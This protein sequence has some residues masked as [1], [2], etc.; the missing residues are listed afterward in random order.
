M[1][2]TGHAVAAHNS[3]IP[4]KYQTVV[5]SNAEQRGFNSRTKRFQY[6]MQEN[7]NPGPGTY[8][9]EKED[10]VNRS[11]SISKKGTGGFA[12]KVR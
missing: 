6:E 2:L 12:S 5:V 3:S 8:G 4:T 10:F 9:V 1:L 7:V 11:P